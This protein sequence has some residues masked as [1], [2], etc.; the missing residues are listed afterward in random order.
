[1]PTK[2]ADSPFY[3]AKQGLITTLRSI[4]QEDGYNTTP[5]PAQYGHK[6]LVD[7]PAGEF[8]SIFVE[9]GNLGPDTE[10]IGG[11]SQGLIRW[12]WPAFIWGYVKT[13]GNQNELYNAGTDLLIDIQAALYD[14]E[15]LPDADGQGTVLFLN[16]GPVVF[17][18]ESFSGAN[19]G[20]FLAEI[21]MIFDTV[22]GGTP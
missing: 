22:R 7:I 11:T 17:D 19:Q 9:L 18:M 15:T 2:T 4:K 5:M 10:Q 16:P 14:N 20:Y 21:G 12:V 13:S 6:L 1:M 8:P 3:K